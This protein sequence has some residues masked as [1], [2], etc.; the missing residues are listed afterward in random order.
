MTT[1]A[2]ITKAEKGKPR[3]W[4]KLH[5]K[6]LGEPSL[7]R[8]SDR[9]RARYFMLYMAAAVLDG[10]G[11][12][13]DGDG[14][15]P[16]VFD[17]L[18]WRLR[19]SVD[20]LT[21]DLRE[22]AAAGLVAQAGEFWRLVRYTEEQVNMKEVRQ[23]ARQRVTKYRDKNRA[24]QE[25]ETEREREQSVSVSN[26]S[27]TR[28]TDTPTDTASTS[29]LSE[30]TPSA[31]TEKLVQQDVTDRMAKSNLKDD[32]LS[33][34]EVRL[35]Y[36]LTGKDAETFVDFIAKEKE[37]GR[38]YSKFIDWWIANGGQRQYWTIAKMRQ[39]WLAAFGDIQPRQP[40][41]EPEPEIIPV[42]PPASIRE[43][44]KAL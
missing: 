16:A 12:V 39:N 25:I 7:F 15:L 26:E 42:S 1:E 41:R 13:Y 43:M 35:R 30:F 29:F 2:Y 10:D 27:V 44:I 4:L 37:A 11:A 8:V 33:T 3:E 34:F 28:Y 18:A 23:Q 32:I 17:D 21:A 20:E 9:A 22:L 24:E 40:I 31:E 38:H 6:Y 36:S 5:T 14:V 19:C